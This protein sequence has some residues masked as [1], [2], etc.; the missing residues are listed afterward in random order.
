MK[1]TWQ[2]KSGQEALE[3]VFTGVRHGDG[4]KLRHSNA[5]VLL[6]GLVTVTGQEAAF[7]CHLTIRYFELVQESHTVKPVVEPDGSGEKGTG[8]NQIQT[9]LFIQ[10]PRS[11]DRFRL[12]ALTA[13]FQSQ[14]SRAHSS[15]SFR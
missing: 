1:L 8:E 11:P 6:V 14:T 10:E 7:V 13:G 15:R 4:P 5:V 9:I 3:E 12:S 2:F